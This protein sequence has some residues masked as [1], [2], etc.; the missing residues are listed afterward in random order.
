MR[1]RRHGR[2]SKSSSRTPGHARQRARL[3]VSGYPPQRHAPQA[4]RRARHTSRQHDAASGR[5]EHL[6]VDEIAQAMDRQQMHFLHAASSLRRHA[7]LDIGCT[8]PRRD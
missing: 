8:Q 7:N 3:R 6:R 5:A 2:R 1:R 4:Q